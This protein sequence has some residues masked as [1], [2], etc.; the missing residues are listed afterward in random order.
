V[1]RPLAHLAHLWHHWWLN[2]QFGHL[3]RLRAAGW[4]FLGGNAGA[5]L[6]E[7]I[8]SVKDPAQ[9]S[10]KVQSIGR[11]FIFALIGVVSLFLFVFGLSVLFVNSARLTTELEKR[12]EH[13]STLAQIS[14]PAPLDHG[15]SDAVHDF[16]EALFQ[17][18]SVVYARILRGDQVIGERQRPEF[19]GQK[20]SQFLF[21]SS[22]IRFGDAKIGK[23]DIFMSR[24]GVRDEL[25]LNV[26]GIVALTMLIIAAIAVTSMVITRRH[27][28]RPLLRLQNSATQIAQGDLGAPIY[29]W[30]SD[31][32]G[33]LAKSLNVMR[34][35]LKD[36]VGA[37]RHSNVE[38]EETRQYLSRLIE[39][40]SDAIISTDAEGKVVLF[41]SGAEAMLGFRREEI[42]GQHV[43]GVYENLERAKEVMRQMRQHG[44]TVAG[45]ETVLRAKDDT[46][47][48]VL[49][50]ASIL[51]DADG[52]DV[53]TVGFN[54]DLRERKRAEEALRESHET[55]EDYS[56]TLEQ[57]V[58]ERTRELRRSV[59]EL[60]AL[61]E[62]SQAVSSTLDLETVLAR[63]IAHAAQLSHADTG[64]IYEFD[65]HAEVF[66]PR[67]SFPV[68]GDMLEV[69]RKTRLRVGDNTSLGQAAARRVPV[70]FRDLLEVP[71]YPVPHVQT[72]IRALLAIPF[73]HEERIV[74]GL[75]VRRKTPGE[76]PAA[77]VELLQTF[78]AQSTLAIQN[79]RLFQEAQDARAAAEEANR[80]KTVFL[81]SMSHELRTPL[82][83]IIGYSEM[84]QEEARDLGQAA[85]VPDLERIHDA[86]RHLLGLINQVLDLSKIEAGKMELFVEAFDI[87][88][89]I[90]DIVGT[91]DPLV[92]KNAN[93]LEVRCADDLGTMRADLTKVRQ[94]LFNLLSNACKFTERGTIT[95]DVAREQM[96]GGP[97][98]TFRVSDTGIGMTPEQMGKL[99]QTFAQADASTTRKYGGTGL[100]L[101]ISRQFCQ[102]MGGDITVESVLGEGSTFTI[103][104]PA[105]VVDWRPAPAPRGEGAVPMP[106][107]GPTVLVIDDDPTVHDLIRRFLSKEG[108]GMVAAMGG[109]EGLRLAKELRPTVITLDVLMPGMDGWAVLT[110]LKADAATADIPVIMLTIMDEKQMGYA[111]GAVDYLTKPVE[112]E[113]LAAVL[114]K[115]RCEAPPC[116][117]LI[118]EDHAETREMLRRFLERDGWTVTEATNGREALERVA[119]NQPE[120]I[121]L[122]LMM[123]EMDGFTFIETLRQNAAWR[124]IPIVV[125]TAKDLTPDDRRRL[126]GT[127]EQILQKGAYSREELLREIHRL[128]TA[129]IRP[130]PLG[131]EAS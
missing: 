44:G 26:T 15:D 70:Q 131:T 85:F 43:T 111:L 28:A 113:R 80:A 93:T 3:R 101:A 122:D 13:A 46:L 7:G 2:V 35:S 53:G 4:C 88:P 64:T 69:L 121:V 11:R 74:G 58:E 86:G 52:R 72:G 8:I 100:G 94:T 27:I 10:P 112:W 42:I 129:C 82:N 75:V 55:L 116:P 97:G 22:D 36:L 87:A 45:F 41:N 49:I 99:F 60:Q 20:S 67:T 9:R 61:G 104:L 118:V 62:V 29:T 54:K 17:D 78:A 63:I 24:R 91:V 109:E 31:E 57:K 50:S 119:A 21:K 96:D 73:L 127:V 51:Y 105:E 110:A 48:P 120:L 90:R 92:Q 12:L 38:L 18:E 79:A 71:D 68:S 56:R 65:E 89:M 115:Y 47:I 128:V 39:N 84:L 66:V 14:L 23:I 77:V 37:L 32:I 1:D 25:A 16:I 106:R 102:M 81:A 124:S 83:A 126:N 125:V 103:R 130:T 33:N 117:V 19:Q 59:E 98:I 5:V 6:Q 30:G 107:G 114:Q 40:S 108:F 76:F 123:P 34:G 95:L